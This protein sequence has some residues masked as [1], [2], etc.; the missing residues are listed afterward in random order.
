MGRNN[1]YL[2]A[3]LFLTLL[4]SACGATAPTA[5][6]QPTTAPNVTPTAT[7]RPASPTV[8]SPTAAITAFPAT[9]TLAPL[10]ATRQS[11]PDRT[12]DATTGV[13]S[14]GWVLA[15][16]EAKDAGGRVALTL[17]FEPLPGQSGGPQADA[18]FDG[19]DNSYTIVVRGVRGATL[20]LRPGDLMPLT[21]A[22]FRG[23]YALPVRDDALF[24]LVIVAA[25]PSALWSLT[26]SEAP[27]AL[28]LIVG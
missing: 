3:V 21:V 17:R 24:A 15:G 28:S 26:A 13:R 1:R 20:V 14:D 6:P 19:S 8:A 10:A 23:Y 9:P 5:T 18:W 16:I 25:R 7:P 4:A 12:P 27:G 2:A 22:P 11:V